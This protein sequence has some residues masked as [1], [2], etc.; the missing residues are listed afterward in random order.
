MFKLKVTLVFGVTLD[1]WKQSYI[2]GKFY[3]MGPYGFPK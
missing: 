3:A 1:N 2:T